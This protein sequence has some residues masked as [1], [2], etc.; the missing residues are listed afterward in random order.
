MNIFHLKNPEALNHYLN[1]ELKTL[2]VRPPDFMLKM[3]LWQKVKNDFLVNDEQIEKIVVDDN[4][5][6]LGINVHDIPIT[7]VIGYLHMDESCLQNSH[8][9]RTSLI[10][11]ITK[12]GKKLENLAEEKQLANYQLFLITTFQVS[13]TVQGNYDNLPNNI[14]FMYLSP[15]VEPMEIHYEMALDTPLNDYIEGDAMLKGLLDFGAN[16]YK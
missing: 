3:F 13:E 15:V 12:F 16:N 1:V 7:S 5:N 9:T 14:K 8:V 11:S 4:N 2:P 6:I 10:S